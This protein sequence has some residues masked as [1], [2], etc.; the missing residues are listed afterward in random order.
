[1]EGTAESNR[2]IGYGTKVVWKDISIWNKSNEREGMCNRGP[3]S[4]ERYGIKPL[5]EDGKRRAKSESL[6]NGFP[7][8]K[9]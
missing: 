4:P 6:G 7:G 2:R 3:K 1:M 5:G 8:G 9:A